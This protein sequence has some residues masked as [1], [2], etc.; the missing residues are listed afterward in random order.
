MKV[1]LKRNGEKG[2]FIFTDNDRPF[3]VAVIEDDNGIGKPVNSW[4][5]GS[6]YSNLDDALD[7]LKE[8][9]WKRN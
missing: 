2:L 6:Y 8:A 7:A 9:V 4:W 1:L 3:V 5:H